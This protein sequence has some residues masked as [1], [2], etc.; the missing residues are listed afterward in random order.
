M[1]VKRMELTG[2]PSDEDMINAAMAG[3]CGANV[4]GLM[5]LVK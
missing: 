2:N 4:V 5:T 1:A 3:F